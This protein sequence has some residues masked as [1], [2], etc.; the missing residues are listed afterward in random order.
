MSYNKDKSSWVIL[1]RKIDMSDNI[2]PQ[3]SV[4]LNCNIIKIEN[5]H[6]NSIFNKYTGVYDRYDCNIL[7]VRVSCGNLGHKYL[8]KTNLYNYLG[9]YLAFSY[10]EKV[11]TRNKDPK[12]T[13]VVHSVVKLPEL[14]QPDESVVKFISNFVYDYYSKLDN[15]PN[16]CYCMFLQSIK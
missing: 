8:S 13:R 2:S 1:Y 9:Y 15:P 11:E 12:I 14:S 5:E 6:F 10:L 4:N 3:Q 16:G 7:L